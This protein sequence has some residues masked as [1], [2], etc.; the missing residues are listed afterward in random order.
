M[1]EKKLPPPSEFDPLVW[2]EHRSFVTLPESLDM[3][4]L[5]PV[6]IFRLFMTDL[7]L[8][9]IVESTNAYAGAK[10]AGATGRGWVDLSEAELV[11]WIAIVIYQGLY[12]MPSNENYW[13][14]DSRTP[15]HEI[16]RHMKLLRYEQIKRYLHISPPEGS[17]RDFFDKLEPLLSHVRDTSKRLYTPSSNVSVDEM[18]IR[19]SGRSA[20]TIRMKNKPVPEGYKVLALCDAGYT[21]A[22]LPESRIESNVELS[23]GTLTIHE[24]DFPLS[25][26]GKKVMYL[27]EQLPKFQNQKFDIYMDNFF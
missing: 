10:F 13:N 25:T 12:S 8:D 4:D 21:Y 14:T 9:T 7:M 1:Q 6:S 16:S 18:M 26:T 19:F 15:V 17:S 3:T 5:H 20:H 23:D 24:D 2:T 11:I 27:A 22:F